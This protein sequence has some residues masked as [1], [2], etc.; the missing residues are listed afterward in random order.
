MPGTRYK[1]GSPHELL[2]DL[3]SI[4]PADYAIAGGTNAHRNLILAGHNAIAV[5]AVAAAAMGFEPKELEFLR[6]LDRKGL[7]TFDL[8]AIWM[9]GNDL[10]EAR[11]LFRK[12]G[13]NK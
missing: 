10:A 9:R 7:G 8:D 2:A 5:D 4:R 12:P 11:A 13:L 1:L 6:I 3:Y